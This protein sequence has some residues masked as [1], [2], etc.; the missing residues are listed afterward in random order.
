MTDSDPTLRDVRA[1]LEI[2][3]RE[4]RALR[5]ELLTELPEAVA[6]ATVRAVRADLGARMTS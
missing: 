2:L 6:A 5:T 4:T 3:G 1:D